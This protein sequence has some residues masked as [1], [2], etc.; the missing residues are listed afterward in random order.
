MTFSSSFDPWNKLSQFGG[1][2]CI[3]DVCFVQWCYVTLYG[4]K[5]SWISQMKNVTLDMNG[6][7]IVEQ[8]ECARARRV[9]ENKNKK[10][11]RSWALDRFWKMSP[12]VIASQWKRNAGARA[13]WRLVANRGSLIIKRVPGRSILSLI[14]VR[15][16]RRDCCQFLA[17]ECY[18]WKVNF[19]GNR[20]SESRSRLRIWDDALLGRGARPVSRSA[21][22]CHRLVR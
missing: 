4:W 16:R 12:K 19:V 1:T 15:S 10:T 2:P 5:I 9:L 11:G 6:T 13:S 14:I 8:V 7:M 17:H 3:S 22:P 21:S 18:Q 20:A